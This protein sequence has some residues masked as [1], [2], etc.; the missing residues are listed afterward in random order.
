[1]FKKIKNKNNKKG[2]T[3]VELLVV[4]AI[5][6]ILTAIAIPSYSAIS[7]N[8]NRKLLKT[9]HDLIA[10]SITLYTT[11]HNGKMPTKAGDLDQY[12]PIGTSDTPINPSGA[13][14]IEKYYNGSPKGA[15]Y[16]LDFSSGVKLTSKWSET[17]YTFT[18]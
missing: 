16:V 9:N 14:V 18:K 5:L 7:K 6:A 4:V 10:S 17:E 11:S 2:F 13:N 12:L 1:M 8:N 15:T 3:L